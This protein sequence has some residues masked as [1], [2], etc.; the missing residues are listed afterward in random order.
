ME[1][2]TALTIG[3]LLGGAVAAVISVS[4]VLATDADV[5][6]GFVLGILFGCAGCAAGM[7]ISYLML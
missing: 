3:N 4:V 6:T 5:A 1:T 7:A 2:R